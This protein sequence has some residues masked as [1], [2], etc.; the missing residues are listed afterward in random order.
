MAFARCWVIRRSFVG[1]L[2]YELLIP[3]E[4]AAHV[5]EELQRS[6]NLMHMGMFAMNACRMEKAFRHF[7]HDIA[8]EDT[9]FETGLGFAVDSYRSSSCY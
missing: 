2:G 8:E 9:P 5:Y 6:A 4:F 1:E 3:T 7:G